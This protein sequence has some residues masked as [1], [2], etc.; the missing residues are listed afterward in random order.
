ML[1]SADA[2]RVRDGCD[3]QGGSDRVRSHSLLVLLVIIHHHLTTIHEVQEARHILLNCRGTGGFKDTG[4][5]STQGPKGTGFGGTWAL[6]VHGPSAQWCEAQSFL[7]ACG[8]E[9]CIRDST[10]L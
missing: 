8:Q 1:P 7:Q 2:V 4:G 6:G 10:G 3:A 9:Q 5:F